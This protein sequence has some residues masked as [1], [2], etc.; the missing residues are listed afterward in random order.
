MGRDKYENFLFMLL[1]FLLFIPHITIETEEILSFYIPQVFT[2]HVLY[3][4]FIIFFVVYLIKYKEINNKLNN[5]YFIL[6]LFV[7]LSL[8]V[9]TALSRNPKISFFGSLDREF[10]FLT[11]AS[12]LSLIIIIP[13]ILDTKEK[14]L[15]F[16][17]I[18][19]CFGSFYSLFGILQFLKLD[20]FGYGRFVGDRALSFFG[21]ANYFGPIALIFFFLSLGYF[22]YSREKIY[23]AFSLINLL[24][25]IVSQ[26]MASIASSI[27]GILL[28]LFLIFKHFPQKRKLVLKSLI[29][30]FIIVFVLTLSGYL[31][32]KPNLHD[33]ILRAQKLTTLKTRI[34]L[35]KDSFKL[36]KNE[37]GT[38]DYFFGIGPETFQREFLPYKSIELERLEPK[39]IFD[40][41]HNFYLDVFIKMGIFMLLS[42]LYVIGK[43]FINSY[44]KI[45][46]DRNF[47][48][49][50]IFIPL[51]PYMFNLLFITQYFSMCMFFVLLISLN[52]LF[53]EDLKRSNFK[54]IPKI[55]I[56]IVLIISFSGFIYFS[57]VRIS[58]K[59]AFFG[60][61]N[62]N[63]YANYGYKRS[64]QVSEEKLKK[65]I[66]IN[67]FEDHY[68]FLLSKLYLIKGIKDKSKQE[69]E[70]S[71]N[72]LLQ[73]KDTYNRPDLVFLILGEDLRHLN[74]FKESEMA[75]KIGVKFNP[76]FLPLRYSLASLY[77]DSNLLDSAEKEVDFS[78]S[79][80]REKEGLKLKGI[81]LI[82]KG[83]VEEGEKF[84]YE[85]EEKDDT[86]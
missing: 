39:R 53:L 50:M 13:V 14:I 19:I 25:I 31:I 40:N 78:L 35:I 70:K 18:S 5:K 30:L 63:L 42:F 72:L 46:K 3:F 45:K 38:K 74:K 6:F 7:S 15:K 51:V 83:M 47:I 34:L 2:F 85:A 49:F 36:I 10:G 21:N 60:Y 27:F 43:V 16:L 86:P 81:I 12:L 20:P 8:F 61:K 52:L 62:L 22:I 73:I 4:F 44:R 17:K 65:A 59:Y 75:F 28:F 71:I 32:L 68:K 69:F 41:P 77:I 67:P 9:S 55:V 48:L 1:V 23:F 57:M 24:G 76:Y 29:F 54:V 79:L 84:L 37:F 66:G 82:K 64:L 58:D 56:S 80:R 11:Q 26:T 33:L